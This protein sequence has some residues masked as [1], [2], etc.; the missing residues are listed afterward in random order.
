[1]S[2][3]DKLAIMLVS[4]WTASKGAVLLSLRSVRP[5][6]LLEYGYLDS[7]KLLLAAPTAY[8]GA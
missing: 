2:S 8:S 1:M 6:V 4:K 3:V 7:K 5:A